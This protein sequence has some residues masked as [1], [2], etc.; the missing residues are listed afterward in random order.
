MAPVLEITLAPE[1]TTAPKGALI[2]S[3]SVASM[4]VHVGSP[5][6]RIEDAWATSSVMPIC[7]AD[8]TTL[9]VSGSG[10]RILMGVALILEIQNLQGLSLLMLWFPLLLLPSRMSQLF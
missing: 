3:S 1:G 4:E 10:A 5:V 2:V 7:L 6:P 9:E 8:L